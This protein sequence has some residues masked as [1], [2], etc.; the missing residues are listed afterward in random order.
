MP[1]R[2]TS[3]GRFLTVSAL[4]VLL[5]YGCS[6]GDDAPPQTIS[7]GGTG[8]DD[9][10]SGSGAGGN[11]GIDVPI[12]QTCKD[13]TD[14][15]GDGIADEIEDQGPNGGDSDGDGIPDRES[16]DSDGDGIPDSVEAG[17]NRNDPCD[18]V[19]DSDDDGIPDFQSRD[20][21]SDGVPD[22]DE[23][24]HC[25]DDCRIKPDCDDDGVIDIVEA[26]IGSDPCS[27]PPPPDAGLYFVVPYLEPPQQKRFDF[28]TG[29]KDADIYFLIDTTG[30]MQPTI[31][32]VRTSLDSVIIPKLL[33]GDPSS[34]PPIPA[35]PGAWVGI[36]TFQDVP[37]LPW[38]EE[39]DDVYR[40]WFTINS[41][42]VYGNM[43]EPVDEGG[44]LRAPDNVKSILGTLAARGGG[45]APEST[46]QALYLASTTAQYRATAGGL[47]PPNEPNG[48]FDTAKWGPN[49]SDPGMVGRACFRPGKLPIFVLISDA[50]FHSGPTT[51]FDYLS[52]AQGNTVPGGKPVNGTVPYA[53]TI[54]ALTS[55]NAKIV[56]VSVSA[57]EPKNAGQARH[58]M[59]DL[60]TQTGSTY[61]DP[62]FGG[63]TKPLV[64]EKDTTTGAVSDEV[65]RLVGLLAGFGV[66][67]V[68]TFRES[69]DCAGGIDCDGN[70]SIDDEY[71]NP[72]D[73]KTSLPF[74][75]T[76]LIKSVKPVEQTTVPK[77]YA[78]I[79]DTTFF[80][81]RGD[82]TVE[83]EV[84][85]E[86]LVLSP[87]RLTVVIALLKVQTPT[88]QA[89]GGA[90]GIKKVYLVIP[91]YIEKP[92]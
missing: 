7:P 52:T 70:G 19:A 91:R 8:G 56:G 33:N 48:S 55:I 53:A 88:G 78:S 26:A 69:Y 44:V 10:A 31:D 16:L 18:P 82:A 12:A 36:G 24:T 58:D 2:S 35:I 40:H 54:Q 57:P 43:T 47:W 42:R 79:N 25:P 76:Q 21:D 81:V 17:P 32:N 22:D 86:N 92:Q 28:S 46:T 59:V 84:T 13:P 63:T 4:G 1:K 38:G 85:A 73:Q 34:S 9:G 15:D 45:D 60:A 62:A 80:G 61:F 90:D 67:N 27:G 68:T 77:P 49:C 37:W 66:N 64:T 20:S 6:S 83:F 74:D 75:A 71:H 50:P 89:L 72:L 11:V 51:A 23:A 29:I 3:L 87:S 39:G 30:S 41:Q 5:G 65:V 14:T